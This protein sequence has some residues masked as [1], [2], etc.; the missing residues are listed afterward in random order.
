MM[1]RVMRPCV[2]LT[3]SVSMIM[4]RADLD[5]TVTSADTDAS[6]PKVRR[7]PKTHTAAGLSSESVFLFFHFA[8]L[9]LN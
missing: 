5:V 1:C 4:I 2:L 7:S 3:A 6:A 8:V 9:G